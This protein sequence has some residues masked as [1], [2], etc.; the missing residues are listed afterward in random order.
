MVLTWCDVSPVNSEGSIN[1]TQPS[2]SIVTSNTSVES[3]S[4][5]LGFLWICDGHRIAFNRLAFEVILLG[6]LR[7]KTVS[8]DTQ[9]DRLSQQW[10]ESNPYKLAA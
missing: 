9:H 8:Q 4:S 6:N 3:F 2:I 7:Y 10:E 5:W 1:K